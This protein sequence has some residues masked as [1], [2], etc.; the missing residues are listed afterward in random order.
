MVRQGTL[1]DAGRIARVDVAATRRRGGSGGFDR[2]GGVADDELGREHDVGERLL[3]VSGAAEQEARG[4]F[5]EFGRVGAGAGDSGGFGD[6][7]AGG[8]GAGDT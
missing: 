4:G 2:A 1:G 5:A 7:G 6:V 3:L 8:V